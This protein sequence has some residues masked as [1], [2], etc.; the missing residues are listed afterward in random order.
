VREG[1]REWK[2]RREVGSRVNER[3]RGTRATNSLLVGE[4]VYE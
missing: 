4:D 1:Y 3:S 2:T